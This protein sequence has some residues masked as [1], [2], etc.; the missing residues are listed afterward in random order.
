MKTF[1]KC[2]EQMVDDELSE[3]LKHA[4]HRP[5]GLKYKV[6]STIYLQCGSVT[7][8]DQL[9]RVE[10]CVRT[11]ADVGHVVLVEASLIVLPSNRLFAVLNAYKRKVSVHLT[12]RIHSVLSVYFNEVLREVFVLSLTAFI[13]TPVSIAATLMFCLFLSTQ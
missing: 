13:E 3:F 12:A 1:K 6:S 10:A 11:S 9:N 7:P 4:P 2:T 5:G 8:I